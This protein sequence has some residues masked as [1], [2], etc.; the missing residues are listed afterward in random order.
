MKLSRVEIHGFKSFAQRTELNFD[1]GIT[2]IVGPNGS[3]KSN[4][5]DAVRW[6]LGEQSAKI[7]RGSKMEDVIFNGTQTRKPLPYCEVSL[8]FDNEDRALN[9]PYSEVLVTRRVYRNGEGEYFLNRSNCRLRDILELFR[10]TGIGKEGYS[11]IGQG[12]I[13]EILSTKGEERREVFEEAA[14]IVTFRVRKEQAE[15]KLD[16][17]RE[18][19]NRVNDIIDEISARIEPLASQAKT[20]QEFLSLSKH[21]RQLEVDSYLIRHDKLYKRLNSLKELTDGLESAIQSHDIQL[22][23]L[24]QLRSLQE[25]MLELLE[26]QDKEAKDTFNQA[27]EN[28]HSSEQEVQ[29]HQNKL[30]ALELEEQRLA[31][32]LKKDEDS[33]IDLRLLFSQNENERL[34][35]L[36]QQKNAVTKLK[37]D[38]KHLAALLH[39]ADEAE[40]NLDIHKGKIITALT[41]MS[42]AKSMQARQQTMLAQMQ[43][44][45][46]EI[47][48]QKDSMMEQKDKLHEQAEN[49]QIL[50]KEADN[51]LAVLI[52]DALSIENKHKIAKSRLNAA[53]ISLQEIANQVQTAQNRLK[54][55]E[56]LTREYEGYN[57]AVKKALQYAAGNPKVYGVVAQLISVPKEYETALDMILGGT[58]QHI[59]TDDEHTA[60]SLID[61]LRN[62]RLGRTTF[63]PISAI[64]SRTLNNAEKQLL[65]HPGCIGIASEL[66][67]YDEKLSGIVESI[68]G[69]TVLVT[70]MDA[71][72]SLSKK[73]KQSFNVVTLAGDVLRAGGAMTG[74]TSQ[75]RASSLLGREREIM[76]LKGFI[77]SSQGQLSQAKD[78]K[79]KANQNLLDLTLL[80]DESAHAVNQQKIIFAR[81]QERCNNA[82]NELE[83]ALKRLVDIQGAMTQLEEAIAETQKD[84]SAVKLL[85]D[86]E[87]VDQQSLENETNELQNLLLIARKNVEQQREKLSSSQ[88]LCNN[89][90]HKFDLVSRDKSRVEKEINHLSTSTQRI[91]LD[92]KRIKDNILLCEQTIQELSLS[93]LHSSSLVTQAKDKWDDVAKR[94]IQTQAQQKVNI[95]G[96]EQLHESIAQD[97]EKLHRNELVMARTE[98]E[99]QNL[100][101]YIFNSYELTH[102]LAQ[103]QRSKEKVDLPQ[104][105]LEIKKIKQRIRD[106]GSINVGAVEEYALTCERFDN[107]T[108]QRNDAQ[109][110]EQDLLDLIEQLLGKMEIQFVAEFKK[111]NDFFTETFVRLFG[112]GKAELILSD[113]SKP[114]S[115]EIEVAAQPPGKKLQMLSLLSGGERALTAIAILFAMLK[116][117]PT[118]FC[119]LDEIEAALDEANINNFADYLSE[120][121][122]ST[123]FIII[124]HRKGTM[125]CCD[126]LY[127]VAMEEKGISSM[128]SVNL[129]QYTAS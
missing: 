50:L 60:K 66:I 2:G 37:L 101:D 78:E 121:A 88:Q 65:S 77:N 53:I 128:V 112:G 55:L 47:I 51:R 15:R 16:K 25:S 9:S 99:L 40:E 41:Q 44:R 67:Q 38:E 52:E 4:I 98:N 63:L 14:G 11:I 81:Q 19:L 28:R 39:E 34:A 106:M 69:R 12:R 122:Q 64:K 30:A 126:V 13:E 115:C 80:S 17:T 91:A 32:Q 73:S 75:S 72:I 89:L 113:V 43:E 83:T 107:L 56:D 105:E 129:Q 10:D 36:E 108:H 20:A 92:I 74:G 117:K 82:Q 23:E 26:E 94:R 71:G 109:Q 42:D 57:N 116:L 5:A 59:V 79:E 49:S 97:K 31:E 54:L 70:N 3:G 62:N 35:R 120:Y 8:Q 76:E 123:Q 22:K 85:A 86:T 118:P 68:L 84:L 7:L 104:T 33:I 114:L 102:A 87:A 111:L 24:S 93:L 58:L 124:T 127:G 96:I 6:V 1:K 45:I 46:K 100:S 110:A 27:Q 103:E 119:I 21:L 29:T 61:Y 95:N 90:A 18:N 48:Q 125:A